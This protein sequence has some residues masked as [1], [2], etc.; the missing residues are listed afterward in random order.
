MEL[1]MEAARRRL[2]L[3]ASCVVAAILIFQAAEMWI[4]YRRM[5]SGQLDTMRRGAALLPGNGEAWDRI[6]R[7]LQFDFANPDPS[8]ALSEYQKAVR[9]DPNSSYYWMDLASA[10]EDAGDLD[11][12]QE[13]FQRAQ[14]VYP[15]SGL[16]A[17]NYG[18]FLIRRRKDSEGY[19]K[20]QQAVRADP[21]LLP[22]AISRTWRSTEDV[23]VLLEQALP[24]TQEAYLRSLAFFAVINQPDAGLAVWQRLISLGKPI[25]L[26][27]VFPFLDKLI[28]DDR[29]DDARRVWHDALKA[30]GLP[31]NEPVNSSIAWNGDFAR[32]FENGGFGWRWDAPLGVSISFDAPPAHAGGRSVRLDFAGG[33]NLALDMPSQ[34]IPVDPGRAYHFHA[35]LR[36]DQITTES[37]VWFSISDPNHSGAVNLLTDNFTGSHAWTALDLNVTTGP[38]TRF[39]LVRLV[40]DPSRLF[41]N[42]L[43]GT[44]WIA[45]VSLVPSGPTG[46]QSP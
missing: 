8:T 45:D 23:K 38:Q 26:A 29:S 13:A 15:I 9:D 12:A 36:T 37:G 1:S 39:L 32:D 27:D 16:V 46:L 22:L 6:G 10:F 5:A 25:A 41:D 35:S 4:A 14:A 30:S 7:F 44:A 33:S 40:R 31:H 21:K 24:P 42:K 43:S 18:N 2:L 28:A 17:W 3:I 19:G 11:H 20:I 34:F